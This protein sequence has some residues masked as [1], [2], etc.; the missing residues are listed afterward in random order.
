MLKDGLL[1]ASYS[2]YVNP[3]TLVH[4][5]QKSIRICVHARR[6]KKIMIADRVKV[7]SMPELLKKVPWVKLYNKLVPQQCISGSAAEQRLP[8]MDR[9]SIPE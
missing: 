6:I 5:E 4:R 8:E 3:P 2:A 7:Q 1:E 9:I